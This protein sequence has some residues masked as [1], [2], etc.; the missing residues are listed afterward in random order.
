MI[1]PSD[2]HQGAAVVGLEPNIVVTI[3]ADLLIRDSELR[4]A[5]VLLRLGGRRFAGPDDAAPA[6]IPLTHDELAAAA[7]LSRNT[8]GA[9]LRKLTARGLIELGYRGIIVRTPPALRAFVDTA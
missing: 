7:N 6:V 8:T 5:A 9:M 2:L 3:A 1:A 4:C